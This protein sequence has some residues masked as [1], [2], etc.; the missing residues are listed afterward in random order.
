MDACH[1]STMLTL[2]FDPYVLWPIIWY[3][4]YA[5]TNKNCSNN[6]LSCI[7]FFFLNVQNNQV[8]ELYWYITSVCLILTWRID[9]KYFETG[10]Y[11]YL[12]QGLMKNRGSVVVFH[13][14]ARDQAQQ[15]KMEWKGVDSSCILHEV[16]KQGSVAH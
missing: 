7:F 3:N 4:I 10:K 15:W 11:G 9:F 8:K 14:A 12:V 13:M 6:L 16:S 5:D 2:T 1:A